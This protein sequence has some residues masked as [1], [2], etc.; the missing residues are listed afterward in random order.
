M[1]EVLRRIGI[2]VGSLVAAW[3]AVSLVRILVTGPAGQGT[4]LWW[5]LIAVLG[6]FIYADIVR[7]ERGGSGATHGRQSPASSMSW[8]PASIRGWLTGRRLALAAAGLFLSAAAFGVGYVLF[9]IGPHPIDSYRL[10]APDRLTV[11]VVTGSVA[12]AWVSD[13][14]ETTTSVTI[15]VKSFDLA[16]GPQ[17]AAGYLRQLTVRLAQ[18]LGD[19]L[20]YDG[21]GRQ[22]PLYREPEPAPSPSAGLEPALSITDLAAIPVTLVVNGSVIERVPAGHAEEP[23]TAE[24]PSLPCD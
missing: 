5:L 19:R 23:L 15:T 10:D 1:V 17:T 4:L 18:P 8:S 9:G 16:I 3:L 2:A 12:W 7:R 24:L 14:T 21:T 6:G 11:E 13:V 20:V 22:V